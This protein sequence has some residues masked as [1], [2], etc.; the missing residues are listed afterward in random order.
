MRC[1]IILIPVLLTAGCYLEAVDQQ[2]TIPVTIWTECDQALEPLPMLFVD[3]L[4][5]TRQQTNRSQGVIWVSEGVH[6]FDA[7]DTRIL[8]L[9]EVTRINDTVGIELACGIDATGAYDMYN[10]SC[11]D[12]ERVLLVTGIEITVYNNEDE[13]LLDVIGPDF[14][15]IGYSLEVD[16]ATLEEIELEIDLDS[17]QIIRHGESRSDSGYY[18]LRAE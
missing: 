13:I 2:D 10:L 4:P 11:D 3:Q 18:C 15:E 1:F 5:L 17:E 8:I 14:Q 12:P 16:L 9:P 6:L 7:V